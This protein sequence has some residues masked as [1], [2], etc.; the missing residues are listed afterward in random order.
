MDKFRKSDN[1]RYHLTWTHSHGRRGAVRSS[2]GGC[3]ARFSRTHE[4]QDSKQAALS[5]LP[6]YLKSKVCLG[7]DM[8]VSYERMWP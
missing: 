3:E 4:S 7:E 8:S 5:K 1:G 2:V 6:A